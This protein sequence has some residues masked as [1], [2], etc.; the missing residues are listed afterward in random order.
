MRI[1]H[2]HIRR[3]RG[4]VS[5]DWD[6]KTQLVCL[7]GPGDS[8]K[9]TILDAISYAL[10]PRWS[11]PIHDGDFHNGDTSQPI[12]IQV[13]VTHLPPELLAEKK[14]GLF[15]RGWSPQE[16]IRD[17]PLAD[18]E[19]ALT[20]RLRIDESL[21]PSWTV[22]KEAGQKSK[23]ITAADRMALQLFRVDDGHIDQHLGWGRGSALA[24]MT[25]DGPKILTIVAEAHRKARA[26][27]F[28]GANPQ[29]QAAADEAQTAAIEL[30]VA[31]RSRFRPGL[32]PRA[33]SSAALIL[34]DG[35]I[36]VAATGLGSRRLTALAIQR[37]QVQAGSIMVIDEVEHG[38]EPHR[39]VH[40]LTKLRQAVT[41]PVADDAGGDGSGQHRYGQILL[42]THSSVTATELR[43]EDLHVVRAR[44][45]KV[46]VLRVPDAL[47]TIT[48]GRAQGTIRAGAAALLAKRI[49]VGEGPT[50][51]GLCRALAAYWATT[52][53][54]PLAHLGTAITNGAGDPQAIEYA[55]CFA[56][57]GYPTALLLDADTPTDTTAAEAAGVQVVRW[58]GGVALEERIAVDL[59]ERML[60]ELVELAITETGSEQASILAVIAARLP[61]HPQ[62]TETDPT[63]WVTP[64]CSLEDI[65]RA[66][67][68]TAK[69]KNWFKRQDRGEALGQLVVRVL[70]DTGGSD[71]AAKLQQLERFAHADSEPDPPSK[72]SPSPNGAA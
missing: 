43:A 53:L 20:I 41:P 8:T 46:E 37:A 54:A 58:S 59:P 7:V 48:H 63:A 14:Y 45:G 65:R 3:F 49:V 5:L 35:E 71:L 4:I 50:E 23:P 32:N 29:L 57:L 28:D 56:E 72:P 36:P 68:R 42:S 9:T 6:V 64:A 44:A 34:H 62:L 55:T 52:H 60:G 70:A 1:R 33:G 19:L 26:A 24:A 12:E 10:S 21:E 30:G 17:D 47:N 22:V 39:L 2:V 67:G 40:L 25:G 16:G 66:I 11:L 18:D 31:P 51:V 69:D 61:G 13:T 27:V 38:L 15:L